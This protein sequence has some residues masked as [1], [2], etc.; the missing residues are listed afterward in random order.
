MEDG[1]ENE[2][3]ESSEPSDSAFQRLIDE[4][5]TSATFDLSE[6]VM[7]G[8]NRRGLESV[9]EIR[10]LMKNEGLSFDE[11]RLQYTKKKMFDNG[12]DPE[13]G[14]PL[15][16]KAHIPTENT[17]EAK[18]ATLVTMGFQVENVVEALKKSHGNSQ[19]AVSLLLAQ[20]EDKKKGFRFNSDIARKISERIWRTTSNFS[21]L[22]LK[23]STTTTTSSVINQES[24]LDDTN[25]LESAHS[26]KTQTEVTEQTS[27]SAQSYYAQNP[28]RQSKS[29]ATSPSKT[30]PSVL[31]LD[32]IYIQ[33]TVQPELQIQ[34]HYP[35]QQ[36]PQLQYPQYWQHHYISTPSVS[37]PPT[38]QQYYQRLSEMM[39]AQTADSLFNATQTK[40][41]SIAPST[42]NVEMA[43][44]TSPTHTAPNRFYLYY[45]SFSSNS[46][47]ASN[48]FLSN[49]SNSAPFLRS[50]SVASP[51]K[52]LN[53]SA[54][55][56]S[57]ST[58]DAK[59]I[60][61]FT[62]V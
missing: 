24:P 58:L 51:R 21:F 11:A 45:P 9:E 1:I 39:S 10:L 6:N 36:L 31:S 30:L 59:G 17:E 40:A 33:P 28:L 41:I 61:P 55:E 7:K 23:S 48:S 8:D 62:V 19:Q 14:L 54:S 53:V 47:P 46:P 16:P 13:T 25:R 52:S 2:P 60:T 43:E 42:S 35:Q 26:P 12:I 22:S 37:E 34:Q 18:I 32:Q 3:A 49:S 20:E 57:P 29:R 5:M 15:D 44:K 38:Q 4:G 50:Q 56:P 27:F